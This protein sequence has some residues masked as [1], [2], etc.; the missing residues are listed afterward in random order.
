[1]SQLDLITL[2]DPRSPASEAYRTLRTNLEFTGLEH[3]LRSLLV[4]SAAGAVKS[5]MIANLAVI[6]A[7]GGRKVI[8]VDGDLRRPEL[9]EIFHLDNDRGLSDLLRPGEGIEQDDDLDELLEESGVDGL[10]VLTSGPLP[11]NPSVLLG[12]PEMAQVIDA[13][14][15]QADLVLF[16]AP[17]VLAV[18]DAS[19]LASRVDGTLLVVR[20]GGTRREHVQ[21]AK[22]LLGKV[23]ARLVGAALTNA[24][25]DGAFSNYYG[26]A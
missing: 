4:T 3:S 14:I 6:M 13:L 22:T 10:R 8:L 20:A 1:M 5:G 11:Q 19:L 2:T 17:P 7:E 9:H 24:R 21:Q 26:K 12:A 15:A 18:T 23:N 16:D 25:L